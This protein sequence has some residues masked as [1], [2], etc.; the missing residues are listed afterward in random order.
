MRDFTY[1]RAGSE[2]DAVA[3]V[4]ADQ[5]AAFL[6]GG[7]NLIDLA[8]LEIE[9]PSQVIDIHRLT[10]ARI[11]RLASGGVS[12]G[13]LARNSDVAEHDLI[14]KEYPALS[15][16]LLSGASPQLRNMATV[17]GNLLQRT[18]CPYFRDT[19]YPCNKRRT[20]S[21][22]AA[23]GGENRTHAILGVSDACIAT[24]PS[25]MCVALVALD[26]V[27]HVRGPRGARS[28]PIDDFH[29]MP[30]Q[31]PEIETVLAHGELITEV[32]LPATP[33]AA[34]SHYVK[35][36]DR[37]SYAFALASAAVALSIENG[38]IR[39]ARVALGGVAT[40]PWRSIEAEKVLRGRA[41]SSALFAAAAAQVV[42][43]ARPQKD[44]AFKV[45]LAKRTVL[46]ALEEVGGAR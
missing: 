35:V 17:G 3:R 18:R 21:G 13:A 29:M 32:T 41:P 42:K 8:Q 7:T 20:G 45:E 9:R 19:A 11:E 40:K 34:H 16:A 36:R 15:E 27:I 46:R 5:E 22:C 24:H 38:L 4:S 6:A 12:I 43:G 2:P 28:I 14:R 23:I 26:A 31:H 44:N 1:V 39:D 33:L 25:D 37:A 10:L 30:D